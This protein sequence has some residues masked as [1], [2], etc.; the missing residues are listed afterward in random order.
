VTDR[1]VKVLENGRLITRGIFRRGRG[2]EIL[3]DREEALPVTLDWSGWLDTDTIA[4]VTNDTSGA[5]VSSESNTTTTNAFTISG[6]ST[7]YVD[8]RITTAAGSI[9]ELRVYVRN[10]D[11]SREKDYGR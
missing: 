8:S 3:L 4:S 2:A 11:G 9:K 1:L 7:G 6:A 5:S 10:Y